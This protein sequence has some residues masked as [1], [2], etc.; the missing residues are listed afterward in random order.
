MSISCLRAGLGALGDEPRERPTG[1]HEVG[2]QFIDITE[3]AGFGMRS[4]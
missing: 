1:K 4:L 3:S 2:R